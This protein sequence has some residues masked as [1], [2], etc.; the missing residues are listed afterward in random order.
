MFVPISP[1][2]GLALSLLA[3]KNIINFT[4][5]AL[6]QDLIKS[7]YDLFARAKRRCTSADYECTF[8]QGSCWALLSKGKDWKLTDI[9]ECPFRKKMEGK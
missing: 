1:I 2:I 7:I 9:Q 8:K 6:L 5:A 4:E 3:R